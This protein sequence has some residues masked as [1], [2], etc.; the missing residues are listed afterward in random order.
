MPQIYTYQ[1][2][3]QEVLDELLFKRSRGEEAMEVGSE[4]LSDKVA[5]AGISN[6]LVG[7]LGN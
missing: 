4:K 7:N 3:I 2:L 5:T 6:F 1:D